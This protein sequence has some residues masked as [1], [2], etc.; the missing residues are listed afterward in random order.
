MH[1][2]TRAAAAEDHFSANLQPALLLFIRHPQLDDAPYDTRVLVLHLTLPRPP[3]HEAEPRRRPRHLDLLI[4]RDGG[5]A[6]AGCGLEEAQAILGKR[7]RDALVHL[8]LK[9]HAEVA[10]LEVRKTDKLLGAER[11]GQLGLEARY[12]R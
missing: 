9:R 3:R 12:L 6:G 1:P 10:E 8:A 7:Q 11:T 5:H 2:H 4:A